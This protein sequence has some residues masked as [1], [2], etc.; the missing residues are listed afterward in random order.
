MWP[1]TGLSAIS[2]GMKPARRPEPTCHVRPRSW[3]IHT[4]PQEMP[5]TTV[6]GSVGS[7]DTEWM[8]GVS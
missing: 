3:V 5:T 7:T 2:G 1:T 8:P 6:S 4:P